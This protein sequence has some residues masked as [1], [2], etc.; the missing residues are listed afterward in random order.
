MLQTRQN[1]L[2]VRFE[3]Q[4]RAFEKDAGA[5][6]KGVNEVGEDWGFECAGVE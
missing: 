4:C 6:A 3:A 1:S 2:G 5:E